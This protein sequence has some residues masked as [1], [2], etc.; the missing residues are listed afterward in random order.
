MKSLEGE[1]AVQAME[2]GDRVVIER[3][4]S[5]GRYVIGLMKA[6]CEEG[7]EQRQALCPQLLGLELDITSR[8]ILVDRSQDQDEQ[9]MELN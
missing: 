7:S 3:R 1:D 6:R 9:M 2:K 4:R 5:H 8:C